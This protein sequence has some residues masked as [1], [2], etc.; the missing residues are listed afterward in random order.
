M[1]TAFFYKILLLCRLFYCILTYFLEE[2]TENHGQIIAVPLKLYLYYFYIHV[3]I[4][5]YSHSDLTL[6]C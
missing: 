6:F 3:F 4:F 1:I 5:F 2:R